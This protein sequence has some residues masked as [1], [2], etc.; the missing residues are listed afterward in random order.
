MRD[1]FSVDDIKS[2]IEHK[3]GEWK[4]DPK[5]SEYL[6]PSTLFG[7][8]FESYLQV[9]N[10]SVYVPQDRPMRSKPE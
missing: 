5:M 8:K 10:K 1:G 7:N 4:D 2:V 6:R 9:V 3:V